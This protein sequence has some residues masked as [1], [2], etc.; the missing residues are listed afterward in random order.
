MFG[1]ILLL[2]SGNINNNFTRNCIHFDHQSTCRPWYS[3]VRHPSIFPTTLSL[4]ACFVTRTRYSSRKRMLDWN[5]WRVKQ[6]KFFCGVI[7]PKI[8]RENVL[9]DNLFMGL[10]FSAFFIRY[11]HKCRERVIFGAF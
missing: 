3:V 2:R 10:N 1:N 8:L 7:R 11:P 4:C 6:P 9:Y 5:T